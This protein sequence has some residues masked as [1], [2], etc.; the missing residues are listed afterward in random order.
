MKTVQQVYVVV[1]S[2]SVSIKFRL[3]RRQYFNI[4]ASSF[5]FPPTMSQRGNSMA[6]ISTEAKAKDYINVARG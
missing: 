4:T 3:F 5:K 1:K 2:P 6:L